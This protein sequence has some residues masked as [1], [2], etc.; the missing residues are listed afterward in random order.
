MEKMKL[1]RALWRRYPR[2]EAESGDYIGLMCGRLKPEIGRI[3]VCL[4]F[5]ESILAAAADFKPDLI[6]THHPFIYGRPREVFRADPAKKLLV[7]ELG[8]LGTAV[9]S[10]HTNFDAAPGGMNDLLAA[11]LGLINVRRHPEMPVMRLGE[12]ETPMDIEAFVTAVMDRTGVSYAG[13]VAEGKTTVRRVG[14][15]A[16]GGSGYWRAAAEADADIYISG[17]CPHHVRRD[18]VRARF[19]YLD[20]PHEVER[21]FVPAL[22]NTLS[23]IDPTLEVLALDHEREARMYIAC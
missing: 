20:I 10:F 7:E 8:G 3:L 15:I 19:N 17:D 16:G 6:V 1:M 2:F 13:L 4:D 23:G 12:L 18:I 5:D 9:V 14:L 22:K 11:R 21:I